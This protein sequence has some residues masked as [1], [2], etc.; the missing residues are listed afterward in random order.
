MN[1]CWN[2]G[3]SLGHETTLRDPVISDFEAFLLCLVS[4]LDQT[5]WGFLIQA[6]GDTQL[7]QDYWKNI[8]VDASLDSVDDTQ[9]ERQPSYL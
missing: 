7:Y 9:S 1:D 2:T 5:D 4:V 8:A 6:S 3:G